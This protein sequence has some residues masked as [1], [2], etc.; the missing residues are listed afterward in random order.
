MTYEELMVKGK[1]LATR[2]ITIDRL[3]DG[4]VPEEERAKLTDEQLDIDDTHNGLLD[5]FLTEG[6]NLVET[7]EKIPYFWSYIDYWAGEDKPGKDTF[8][9]SYLMSEF[10]GDNK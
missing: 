5:A 3:L 7:F 2:W 9:A 6:K 10:Y 4:D 8:V 1:E